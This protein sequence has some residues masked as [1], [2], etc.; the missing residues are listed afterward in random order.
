MADS[1]HYDTDPGSKKIRPAS[2]SSLSFDTDPDPDK[3]EQDPDP[4]KTEFNNR[5]ILKFGKKRSYPMFF[6]FILLN[7][8]SVWRIQNVLMRIRVLLFMLMR[9]R[10]QM[11]LARVRKNMSTKS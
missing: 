2:G 5:K 9:I 6:V 3:N 7:Y 8:H 1:C 11:F 10:I 4:G